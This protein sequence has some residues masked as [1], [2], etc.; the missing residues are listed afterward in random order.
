MKELLDKGVDD[1]LLL[2][3]GHMNDDRN[4]QHMES[5]RQFVRENALEKNIRFLGLI[6]YGDVVGLMR[7]A[8]SVINP[9]LF[10]GWS[11][12]VEEAKS[13]GKNLIL[14][15]IEVHREQSPSGAV[16]F[17]PHD[18]AG[19]A[20]IMKENWESRSGGPD[21]ELETAAR[22]NLLPRTTV[23]ATGFQN[24]VLDVVKTP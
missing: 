23:F 17:N 9:S 8:V 19:L 5:L 21:L 20:A 12:T 2:C 16:Y 11:T 1:I 10:E 13:I 15:D 24:L 18:H 22:E 4:L 6:P 7:N 3:S 14:S